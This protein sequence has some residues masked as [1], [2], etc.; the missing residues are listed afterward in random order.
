M[1]NN[2]IV[3][4]YKK[5]AKNKEELKQYEIEATKGKAQLEN[6]DTEYLDLEKQIN[7]KKINSK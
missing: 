6:A 2:L 3:K 4:C 1:N 5:L 7:S